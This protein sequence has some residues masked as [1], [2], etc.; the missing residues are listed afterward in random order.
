MMRALCR[1][2]ARASP[3]AEGRERQDE[4]CFEG[5]SDVT[6]IAFK[7]LMTAGRV[8]SDVGTR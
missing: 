8:F 7:P 6:G 3:M 5:S 1:I 2:G 4:A